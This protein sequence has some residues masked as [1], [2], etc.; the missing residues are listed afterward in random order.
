MLLGKLRGCVIKHSVSTWI[1]NWLKDKKQSIRQRAWFLQKIQPQASSLSPW[2]SRITQPRDCG[3][4]S[5]SGLGNLRLCWKRQLFPDNS[6]K[7]LLKWEFPGA[8]VIFSNRRHFFV[9]LQSQWLSVRLWKARWQR[10]GIEICYCLH[11]HS[12]VIKI[13]YF[14]KNV[15]DEIIKW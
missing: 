5:W 9:H 14:E 11:G 1:S 15:M 2:Y 6:S 7:S 3:V 10:K 12:W 13:H 4:L 8:W